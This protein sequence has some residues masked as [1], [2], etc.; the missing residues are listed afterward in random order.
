MQNPVCELPPG[1]KC[2][3]CKSRAEIRL[4]S[5]NTILCRECFIHYCRTAVSRAME[6][7]GIS[8]DS[9]LLIAVSGGK[10][11]LA[12]WDLLASLGY[13]TR[14]LHVYLGVPE[15]SDAS[16]EAVRQYASPRGLPWVQYSL[17]DIF[18]WTVEEVRDRTRRSI[19]SICGS[20]KRQ[21]LN[22]L[23]VRKGYRAIVS[24]HNLDDEAGR[25]LGN[26]LR[27][28]SEYLDKQYP[29]LPSPHPLMPAK[30]KPL[31]RL[32]SHEL[33][34]YCRVASIRPLSSPCPYSHGATSHV[35]KEALDFIE[36]RM[37]GSKRD[38]L[39]SYLRHKQPP[40]TDPSGMKFCENCGEP[41]YFKVCSVCSLKE[42]LEAI[43]LKEE[44]ENEK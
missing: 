42:R 1:A 30:V 16:A 39:Y 29:Y 28:R 37:P 8:R 35:I 41:A 14:G 10:D 33:R 9:N 6:K 31:Y 23:T 21:Y 24:G 7:F 15:F 18:G 11:S 22:R 12:V 5:H 19:C 25:L 2:K 43:R 34:T 44:G 20:M 32:E 38:F 36:N 26:I 17:K 3:R 4:P 40:A 27:H 13:R